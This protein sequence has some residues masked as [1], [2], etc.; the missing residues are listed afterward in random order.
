MQ[1]WGIVPGIVWSVYSSVKARFNLVFLFNLG[2]RVT[3]TFSAVALS[4][5]CHQSWGATP[6]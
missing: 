1:N 2:G 6:G 5:G 4:V 3:R